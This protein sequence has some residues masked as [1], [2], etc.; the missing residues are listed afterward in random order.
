[1]SLGKLLAL[2]AVTLGV[3]LVFAPDGSRASDETKPASAV[4][5]E[6]GAP[7]ID[8]LIDD[9]VQAINDKDKARLRQ[10]RVS[11]DEYAGLILPGS[12]EPGAHR[13]QYNQEEVEYLWGI[14]NGK[15][16]YAEATLLASFGGHHATVTGKEFQKGTKKYA[17]YTAY[18]QL[19]LTLKDDKGTEATMRIGSIAEVDGQF[20][21]ISYV[22]D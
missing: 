16:I 12:V 14:V 21:F 8:K 18:K 22:Q 15:S 3:S 19:R 4:R 9:F 13:P 11:Q 10:L 20:K 17:D 1:M 2:G 5:L 6:H 7:S